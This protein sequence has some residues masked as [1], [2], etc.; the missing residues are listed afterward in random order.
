MAPHLAEECWKILECGDIIAEKAWPKLIK[1]YL[2]EE[3]VLIIVQVNGKKRGEIV[4]PK[5]TNQTTIENEALA[6][7]NV[8]K[9]I[10]SGVKKIIH[11]PNRIINVVI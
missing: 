5:D 8:K 7:D 4:I 3:D 9:I 6:L 10:T 1:E 11:V 2:E